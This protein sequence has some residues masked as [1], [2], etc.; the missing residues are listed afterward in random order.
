[1][2]FSRSYNR[3]TIEYQLP[4]RF[5]K[6]LQLKFIERKKAPEATRSLFD[7]HTRPHS[8][9]ASLHNSPSGRTYHPKTIRGRFARASYVY[10][11]AGARREK[12]IV[13]AAA[14]REGER[15]SSR[16]AG[17]PSELMK[18]AKVRAWRRFCPEKEAAL[19]PAEACQFADGSRACVC[20]QAPGRQRARLCV[21]RAPR[22][23]R[24]APIYTAHTR[25]I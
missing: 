21:P 9:N 24:L 22:L 3:L 17:R 15:G 25:D 14:R 7:R 18:I 5:D 13:A 23:D 12:K 6:R 10:R 11:A 19:P 8:S 16:P 1:M 4:T 2:F 20:L